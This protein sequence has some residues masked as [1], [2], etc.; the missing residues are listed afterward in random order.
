MTG[1]FGN[2]QRYIIQAPTN[3]L[4]PFRKSFSRRLQNS[5]LPLTHN[6]YILAASSSSF[7]TVT[8]SS[9]SGDDHPGDRDPVIPIRFKKD[10]DVKARAAP[11]HLRQ[12]YA[13]DARAMRRIVDVM[14]LSGLTVPWW[15]ASVGAHEMTYEC[16][17]KLGSPHAT[18]CFHLEYSALG[19]P[20]DSIKVTPGVPKILSSS[21]EIRKF[22]GNIVLANPTQISVALPSPLAFP[23]SSLGNR[24]GPPWIR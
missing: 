14:V 10:L 12:A 22:F 11:P 3:Y 4:G 2:L 18:D 15:Q 19:A 21:K 5:R 7:F 13:K 23:F 16:D 9:I 1:Q 24:L 8:V 20:S 17:S 6:H